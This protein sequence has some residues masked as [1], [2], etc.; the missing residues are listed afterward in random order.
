METMTNETE[1]TVRTKTAVSTLEKQTNANE[2]NASLH[3][4][5]TS[6]FSEINVD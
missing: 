4:I 1:R 3:G 2:F 6:I 5:L